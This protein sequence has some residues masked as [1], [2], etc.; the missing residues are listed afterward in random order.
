VQPQIAIDMETGTTK[1]G[2]LRYQELLP[3]DAVLYT[4]VFYGNERVKEGIMANV[5]RD[6]V[7]TAIATHVQLGGDV[8]MGRGIMEVMW[9][10]E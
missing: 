4:L 9:V 2:S 1:D 10:S 8:T 7:K 3:A 5:I 6:H